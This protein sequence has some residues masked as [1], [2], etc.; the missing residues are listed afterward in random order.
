M[1][2]GPVN[3]WKHFH[4]NHHL[5]PQAALSASYVSWL[6]QVLFTLSIQL[7]WAAIGFPIT[8][9]LLPLAWGM[10]TGGGAHSGYGGGIAQ[11]EQHQ[12][13]HN[14]TDC[15]YGLLMIADAVFGTHWVP[16]Q[17]APPASEATRAIIA[18]YGPNWSYGAGGNHGM[19]GEGVKAA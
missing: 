2:S 3:L 12:A 5:A 11:G 9:Y 1:R 4:L 6:E 7:P 8:P 16:G 13:H 19:G 18:A 14:F 17:P 15:N 10:L